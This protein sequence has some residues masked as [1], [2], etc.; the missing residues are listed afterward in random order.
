MSRIRFEQQGSQLT[1]RVTRSVGSMLFVVLYSGLILLAAILVT[2]AYIEVLS[3]GRFLL[4]CIWPLSL[5]V[6][7]ASGAWGIGLNHVIVLAPDRLVITR[8]WG[9][10]QLRTR[11]TDLSDDASFCVPGLP[12]FWSLSS[13]PADTVVLSDGSSVGID[14]NVLKRNE[15]E[16]VAA[17]FNQFLGEASAV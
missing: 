4:A 6:G 2:S 9:S 7:V 15:A 10:R 13:S 11:E 1:L 17:R 5:W 16:A 14:R 8:R 3:P 12:R